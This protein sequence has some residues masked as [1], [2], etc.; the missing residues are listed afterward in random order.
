M[1][2]KIL[3]DSTLNLAGEGKGHLLKC[4]DAIVSLIFEN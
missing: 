4:L 3:I 1:K 2:L